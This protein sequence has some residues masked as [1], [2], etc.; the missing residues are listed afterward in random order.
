MTIKKWTGNM[1]YV[2]L[3]RGTY[4]QRS[5]ACSF[6]YFLLS[7]ETFFLT[8][9]CKNNL[10]TSLLLKNRSS[11]LLTK[12]WKTIILWHHT[13][14]SSNTLCES[15]TNQKQFYFIKVVFSKTSY[16]IIHNEGDKWFLNNTWYE[17]PTSFIW[18]LLL[19]T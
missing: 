17:T 6:I 1:S 12:I 8:F 9:A 18:D 4:L 7:S 15:I 19:I 13:A 14:H 10:L 2:G 3:F 11:E 5:K 16:G